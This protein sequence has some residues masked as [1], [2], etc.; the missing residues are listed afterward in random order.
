MALRTFEFETCLG[1]GGFGEVYLAR[2]TTSSG[3]QRRVAVKTLNRDVAG[4]PDAARRMRDEARLLAALNHR[5]VLQV[6]D[7]VDLQGRLALVTEYISG[8]DLDQ[9][10]DHDPLPASV[11]FEVVSEVAGALHAALRTPSPESAEPMNLVHRDIKPSNVRLSPSGG[12]KL[13]DFGI[14]I[15]PKVMR[16]AKTSTGLVVGTMGYLS[17]DRLT[18]DEVL[19]DGDI[20]ALGCVLYEALTS[21]RLY[22]DVGRRKLTQMAVDQ[23]THD[24]FIEEMLAPLAEGLPAPAMSLLSQMLSYEPEERPTAD[25]VERQADEVA[26]QLDGPS[27]RRWARTRD[28]P[29]LAEFDGPLAGRSLSA[30]GILETVGTE[31]EHR[32]T[33]SQETPTLANASPAPAPVRWKLIG[34]LAAVAGLLLMVTAALG[35]ALFSQQSGSGSPATVAASLATPDPAT[36]KPPAAEADPE[37]ASLVE[38]PPEVV[39]SVPAESVP[40]EPPEPAAAP[41]E[42]SSRVTSSEK[43]AASRSTTAASESTT[44]AAAPT[45]TLAVSGAVPARLFSG[46]KAHTAGAVPAG[47]HQIQADFGSGWTS[48]GNATVTAG[49]TLTLTCSRMVMTCK[50][51]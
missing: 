45:G 10:V 18:S 5:A 32:A 30:S 24:E 27:I 13:L 21:R 47:S 22:K 48:A 12:V 50:V 23:Q 39:A 44:P 9:V 34:A 2:M 43:P 33:V 3:L 7:L 28:W 41:P 16:E 14:A 35:G 15:S 8:Q 19:P 26:A 11:A 46:G 4:D 31:V 29:P 51:D 40:A 17:P 6:H 1:I 36:P 20:Y 49:Q 38:P 25:L 42:A 37:P